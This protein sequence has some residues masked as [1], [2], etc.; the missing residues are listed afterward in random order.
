MGRSHFTATLSAAVLLAATRS[1]AAPAQGAD[2]PKL[3]EK[4]KEVHR[5]IIAFDSHLDLPF[6]YPGASAGF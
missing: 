3:L 5:R 2:D 6:D 1:I 4:A